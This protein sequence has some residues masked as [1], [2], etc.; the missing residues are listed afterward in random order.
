MLR[1]NILQTLDINKEIIK[2]AFSVDEN[3]IDKIKEFF[4]KDHENFKQ[5][6]DDIFSS[7]MESREKMVICYML[8]YA[9]G[10]RKRKMK[11]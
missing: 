10:S 11:N 1:N 5:I 3:E 2:D 9:N 4:K 8:G 7:D 6:V